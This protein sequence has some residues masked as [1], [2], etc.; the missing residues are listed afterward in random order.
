M[1]DKKICKKCGRDLPICEFSKCKQNKDGLQRYCKECNRQYIVK[2][3]EKITEYQKEYYSKNKNQI[4]AQEAEY[5]RNNKEIISTHSKNYYNNNKS[6]ILERHR[7]WEEENKNTPMRVAHN[8]LASYNHSDKVFGR[9]KGDLTAKW[10][11]EN[12]LLGSCLYC[13]ETDWTKLG[14]HRIDNSKPHTK[15]NVVCCCQK[16]HKHLSRK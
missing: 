5:Y 2:H 1:G 9:G 10:I 8:R 11:V 16:C 13:G 15:D 14:C 6:K 3:K 7:K 12:I 4:L